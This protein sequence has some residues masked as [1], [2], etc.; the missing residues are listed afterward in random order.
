MHENIDTRPEQGQAKLARL[1]QISQPDIAP[2]SPTLATGKAIW[3]HNLKYTAA[4]MVLG[5][6]FIKA[7]ILSWFRIQ[8][9]FRLASFHMYGVIGTAVAVGAASVFLI[10]RFGIKTINGQAISIPDKTFDKGHIYGGLIFGL[11]WAMTGACPGPLYAQIA[12][13]APAIA[14]TLLSAIL[15]TWT[16]GYLKA[17]LP[18]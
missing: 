8:E 12:T 5:A 1:R 17:K 4:G 10:K 14:V 2:T 9:M 13:G 11:G 18:H 6:I 15:G 3:W 7:E 16:Y